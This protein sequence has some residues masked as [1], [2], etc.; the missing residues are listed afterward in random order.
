MPRGFKYNRTQIGKKGEDHV[1]Q[2]LEK[3]GYQILERNY[4]VRA[5]EIDI[6]AQKKEVIVFVEVKYRI[7]HY[8]NLSEVI[9]RAKQQKIIQAARFFMAQQTNFLHSYRFDVALVEEGCDIMYI[10]NAFVGEYEVS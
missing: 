10:E 3:N 9:T 8:F 1:V 4:R 2:W 5:G 7:V 6:I